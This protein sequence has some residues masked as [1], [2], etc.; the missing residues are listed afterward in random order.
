MDWKWDFLIFAVEKVV[1][2][3]VLHSGNHQDREQIP[4]SCCLAKDLADHKLQEWSGTETISAEKVANEVISLH[5][6]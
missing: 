2:A 6:M 1:G 3:T 5:E 4:Q